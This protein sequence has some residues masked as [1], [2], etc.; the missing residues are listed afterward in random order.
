ME[1]IWHTHK[2]ISDYANIAIELAQCNG[3]NCDFDISVIEIS[4][5]ELQTVFGHD[6][7][8]D[9]YQRMNAKNN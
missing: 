2:Q 6:D 1:P 5:F 9:L 3:C 4:E 7:N 8:C